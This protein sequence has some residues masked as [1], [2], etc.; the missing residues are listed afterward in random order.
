MS[1]TA[2]LADTATF[3]AATPR[4]LSVRGRRRRRG[5]GHHADHLRR[6]HGG[7]DLGGRHGAGRDPQSDGHLRRQ[8]GGALQHQSQRPRA[9]LRADGSVFGDE[10]IVENRDQGELDRAHPD[11][12][13][14]T[15]YPRRCRY[16]VECVATAASR[17][18]MARSR[19]TSPR[20][21]TAPTSP[22]RRPPRR[23]PPLS[24]RRLA[25]EAELGEVAAH[26]GVDPIA[27]ARPRRPY[28]RRSSRAP[29]RRRAPI[30]ASPLCSARARR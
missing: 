7:G 3:R 19:A 22:Q 30:A 26:A 5:L 21:S 4:Y 11:E 20:S 23:P 29:A 14:T 6:R 18:P 28:S 17:S 27:A 16:F 10:Y 9:G 25:R 8:G 12:E 24:L 2:Q 13:W 15:G 1:E